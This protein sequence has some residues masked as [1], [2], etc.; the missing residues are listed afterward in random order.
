MLLPSETTFQQKNSATKPFAKANSRLHACA[1][2]CH[3]KKKKKKKKNKLYR[4]IITKSFHRCSQTFKPPGAGDQL[5]K[6]FD[7]RTPGLPLAFLG[8]SE[9]RRQKQTRE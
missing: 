1:W 2:D 7:R 5:V 6:S 4:T 8:L 3:H 9:F